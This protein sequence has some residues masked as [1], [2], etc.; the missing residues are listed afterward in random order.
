MQGKIGS[1]MLID[2]IEKLVLIVDDSKD[3]RDV[4]TQFLTGE[5]FRVTSATD[6]QEALE[7]AARLQPDLILMDLSLPG[8][9]GWAAT[10]RLKKGEKT[11]HIPVVILTADSLDGAETVIKEGCE[12]F[13]IKPCM[14]KDLLKE[15]FRVLQHRAA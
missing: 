5:G 1:R 15:V 9:G 14:P 4:Y 10:Q 3:I 11:K 2:K 8:I 13:L 6:G 7:E 12:G